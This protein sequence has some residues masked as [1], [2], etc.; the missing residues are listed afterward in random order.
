MTIP[1]RETLTRDS[2]LRAVTPTGPEFPVAV[3]HGG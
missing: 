1:A 3:R 2:H